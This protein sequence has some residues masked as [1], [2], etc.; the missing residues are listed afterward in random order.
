MASWSVSG[1]PPFGCG[2]GFTPVVGDADRSP[3]FEFANRHVPVQASVAVV[4]RPLHDDHIVE[5]QTSA[6]LEPQLGEVALDIGDEPAGA[7]DL[8]HL[9]PL[10]YDVLSQRCPK[11]GLEA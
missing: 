8:P 1:L 6:D 10:A 2:R 3:I 9:R 4:A 11:D 5:L 7:H